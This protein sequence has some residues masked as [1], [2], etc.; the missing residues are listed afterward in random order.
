MIR[1]F[2]GN[3]QIVGMPTRRPSPSS[4]A[5]FVLLLLA[6]VIGSG[7]APDFPVLEARHAMLAGDSLIVQAHAY[8]FHTELLSHTHEERD[9]RYYLLRF[10]LAFGGTVPVKPTD[11]APSSLPN[12]LNASWSAETVLLAQWPPAR[13]YNTAWDLK[14]L[15]WPPGKKPAVARSW[16]WDNGSTEFPPFAVSNDGRYAWISGGHP[17]LIDLSTSRAIDEP[18]V[19]EMLKAAERLKPDLEKGYHLTQR[20]KYLIFT[21]GRGANG[22]ETGTFAADGKEYERGWYSAFVER[23]SGAVGAFPDRLDKDTAAWPIFFQQA[24]ESKDGELL[25]MYSTADPATGE[26]ICTLRDRSLAVR[27]R[28]VVPP[29]HGPKGEQ[30]TIVQAWDPGR[31][32]VLFYDSSEL[33]RNPHPREIAVWDYEAN[34]TQRMLIDLAGSFVLRNNAY[35]PKGK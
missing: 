20:L 29:F 26:R 32:R 11:I 5:P 24:G 21:P 4:L 8:G 34:T 25:L 17:E 1:Q 16:H 33:S 35:V 19:S 9:S 30:S 22:G 6:I 31:H 27:Y 12:L 10:P 13:F 7:C 2:A 3:R 15:R 18:G 28:T 14:L 23:K